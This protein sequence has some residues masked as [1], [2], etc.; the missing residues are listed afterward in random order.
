MPLSNDGLC[1]AT[2]MVG[3]K[4]PLHCLSLTVQ[5]HA[6]HCQQWRSGDNQGTG[7]TRLASPGRSVCAELRTILPRYS[8]V[9]FRVHAARILR[10]EAP[11]FT[12]DQ[13]QQATTAPVRENGSR[14][15]AMHVLGASQLVN[16]FHIQTRQN[17][18]LFI[19]PAPA[20]CHCYTESP[21]PH[22]PST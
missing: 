10:G 18:R 7:T 6:S 21:L 20:R 13:Q 2:C 17:T 1:L 11:I 4:P 3:W 9:R 14:N 8:G 19:S 15:K 16:Y 5:Q 22:S 12:C